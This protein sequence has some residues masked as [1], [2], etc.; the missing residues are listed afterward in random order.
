MCCTCVLSQGI[1]SRD[2]KKG[3]NRECQRVAYWLCDTMRRSLHVSK[4]T[5]LSPSCSRSLPPLKYNNNFKIE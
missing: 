5:F 2:K 4:L 3:A 1:K